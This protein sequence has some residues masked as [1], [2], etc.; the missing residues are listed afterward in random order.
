MT[1]FHLTLSAEELHQLLTT[2][3]KLAPSLMQSFLNQLLQK[4]ASE[5][6]QAEPYERTHERTTYRNG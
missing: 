3:G 5:Q 6:I 1:H 4:Q 2:H